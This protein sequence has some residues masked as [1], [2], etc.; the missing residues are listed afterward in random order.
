MSRPDIAVYVEDFFTRLFCAAND[1]EAIQAI[2]A[3]IAEDADMVYV[4][5]MS[6]S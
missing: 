6:R 2:D 1:A 4:P 5:T 3:E